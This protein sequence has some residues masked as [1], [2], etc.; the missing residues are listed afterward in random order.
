MRRIRV[1]TALSFGNPGD[2]AFLFH[3][4]H[5]AVGVRRRESTSRRSEHEGLGN[6]HTSSR[7]QFLQHV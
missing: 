4:L 7:T 6:G 1:M 5:S 3:R 2:G